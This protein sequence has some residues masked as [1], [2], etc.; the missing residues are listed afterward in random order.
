MNR[1]NKKTNE[2]EALL[3]QH[4]HL[5][6]IIEQLQQSPYTNQPAHQDAHLL[7]ITILHNQL[8]LFL[9]LAPAN[10]RTRIRQKPLQTPVFM[11][12][13]DLLDGP[14]GLAPDEEDRQRRG[15]REPVEE[16]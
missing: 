4:E 14:R 16:W 5:N 8:L 2:H 15:G 13:L 12:S 1:R 3:Q 11:R 6:W 7:L 10:N 9:L